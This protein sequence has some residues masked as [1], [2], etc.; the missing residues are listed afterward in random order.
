MHNEGDFVTPAI[1]VW[2]VPVIKSKYISL[3]SVQARKAKPLLTKNSNYLLGSA[4]KS[5]SYNSQQLPAPATS[6]IFPKTKI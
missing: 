2:E 5:N 3:F 6:V 4:D 1:V